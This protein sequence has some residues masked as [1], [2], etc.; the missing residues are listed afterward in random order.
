M[1]RAGAR[2]RTSLSQTAADRETRHPSQ[3]DWR[4]QAGVD[5]GRKGR[6]KCPPNR[7][8][9]PLP[10]ICLPTPCPMP[11][12]VDGPVKA[13]YGKEARVTRRF[14]KSCMLNIQESYTPANSANTG[15]VQK[16]LN[17]CRRTAPEAER[18][19]KFDEEVAKLDPIWRS[20]ADL[21]R[22]SANVG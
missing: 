4:A 14:R 12:D 6:G 11:C 1:A 7:A 19:L 21:G 17:N 8:R 10:C 3:P 20:W 9:D 13:G 15:V 18:W 5:F 16:L 22:V 2:A